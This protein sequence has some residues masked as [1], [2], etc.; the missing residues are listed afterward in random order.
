MTQYRNTKDEDVTERLIAE[1][2]MIEIISGEGE[3]GTREDYDGERTVEAILDLLEE[4]R[5]EGDRW[6]ILVIDGERI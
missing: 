6:A 4:E 1:A 2:E 3:I 5:C